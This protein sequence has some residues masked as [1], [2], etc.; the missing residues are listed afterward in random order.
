MSA[1]WSSALV[2]A[3]ARANRFMADA[4]VPAFNVPA[5]EPV[6]ARKVHLIDKQGAPQSEIR[7]EV[8]E[9]LKANGI[10]VA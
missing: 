10:D 3:V 2:A 7:I 6:R 1:P 5:P 4:P 9:A 8:L